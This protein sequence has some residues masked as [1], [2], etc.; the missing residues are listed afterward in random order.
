MN[1]MDMYIPYEPM[2]NKFRT[3]IIAKSWHVKFVMLLIHSV[4]HTN[5][6]KL[7]LSRCDS[8]VE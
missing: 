8:N 4:I 7:Q 1:D 5:P 3:T 6:I 2:K